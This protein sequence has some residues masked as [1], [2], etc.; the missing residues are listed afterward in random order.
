LPNPAG[1]DTG[2]EFVEL[3]CTQEICRSEDILLLVNGESVP[4]PSQNWQNAEYF[5]LNDVS[6]RNSDLTV[7]LFDIPSKSK[8][9]RVI[10]SAKDGKSYSRFGEEWSWAEPTPNEEIIYPDDLS[11][12]SD[13]DEDGIPDSHELV[14]DLNPFVADSKDSSGYR[15]FESYVKRGAK[16]EIFGRKRRYPYFREDAAKRKSSGGAPFKKRNIYGLDRRE[17]CF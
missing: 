1:E 4:L 8:E 13:A 9:K 17:W 12:L 3:Q 6:L 7:E 14:L 16:L 11:P 10:S 15:L 5:L 2:N